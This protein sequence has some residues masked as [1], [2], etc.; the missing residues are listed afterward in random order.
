MGVVV[1]A[2][3]LVFIYEQLLLSRAGRP[4]RILRKKA[5]RCIANWYK[6]IL[7]QR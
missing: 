3:K 4:W 5:A 7:V 6:K 1:V 2:S